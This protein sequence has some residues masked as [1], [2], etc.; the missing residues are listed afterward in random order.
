MMAPF[1]A[2]LVSMAGDDGL[3]LELLKA[4]GRVAEA[5]P[6]MVAGQ[7][8]RLEAVV[9]RSREEERDALRRLIALTTERDRERN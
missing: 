3:R 7:I 5:A 8:P 1:V 2:P 4:L 6:G 9:D